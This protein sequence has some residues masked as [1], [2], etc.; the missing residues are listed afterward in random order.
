MRIVLFALLLCTLIACKDKNE[1]EP[2]PYPI[3]YTFDRIDQSDEGQ[4]RVNADSTLTDLSTDIGLFGAYKD[5]LKTELQ[6]TVV[7]NLELEGVEIIDEDDIKLHYLLHGF[8]IVTPVKYATVNGDIVL[9]DTNQLGL[10]SYDKVLDEFALCGATP[11]A[12]PGPNAVNPFGLPY[13][14]FNVNQC[15]EGHTNRQYAEDYLA[16]T[17]LYPLDTIGV[18]I[19][20]YLFKKEE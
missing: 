4:Y 2:S 17:P 7:E 3:N 14:N 6:E 19:T 10:I 8:E 15:V 9:T 16:I 1:G 13:L 11:F 12:L 5:S 18:L 20:R